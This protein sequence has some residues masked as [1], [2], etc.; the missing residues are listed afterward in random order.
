VENTQHTLEEFK[1]Q[2]EAKEA[3][4]KGLSAE[5]ELVKREGE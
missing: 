2:L 4:I 5:I 3:E 1:T